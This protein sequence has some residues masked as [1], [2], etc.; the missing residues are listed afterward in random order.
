VKIENKIG[1]DESGK[2][3]FFGYLVIAG[4]IV[5]DEKPLHQLG[6]RDS[7]KMLDS[8]IHKNATKIRKICKY[9]IVKISPEKYN[10]LYKKFNNLNKLLAWGHARVIENLLSYGHVDKII[11][12]KFASSSV[13]EEALFP[14]GK[15]A[16]I[17]QKVRGEEDMAVAAASVIARSE[18]LS[19][20]R[21]IGRELGIVIPKGSTSIAVEAARQI[22]NDFG[23]DILPKIVK[24]NFK[25]TKKL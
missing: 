8:V 16:N 4:V 21:A 20:L 13:L 5:N 25:I 17:I 3:D 1:T 7:K 6:I 24:M 9:D 18:F 15:K 2:G 22:K 23:E 12:D 11:V 10:S 19:S 14:K